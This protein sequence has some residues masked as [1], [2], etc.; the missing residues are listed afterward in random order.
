MKKLIH[1]TAALFALWF[2]PESSRAAPVLKIHQDPQWRAMISQVLIEKFE[3]KMAFHGPIRLANPELRVDLTVHDLIDQVQSIIDRDFSHTDYPEILHSELTNSDGTE[4][5]IRHFERWYDRLNQLAESDSKLRQ[6]L[7]HELTIQQ[8]SLQGIA[9]KNN[10]PFY[11]LGRIRQIDHFNSIAIE[12]EAPEIQ[13][14]LRPLLPLTVTFAQQYSNREIRKAK[15]SQRNHYENEISVINEQEAL[16]CDIRSKSNL[17]KLDAE[18]IFKTIENLPGK[19]DVLFSIQRRLKSPLPRLASGLPAMTQNFIL[20]HERSIIH[21]LKD[22][23]WEKQFNEG[24]DEVLLEMRRWLK[25]NRS[26]CTECVQEKLNQYNSANGVS[27]QIPWL[28]HRGLPHRAEV[29]ESFKTISL[30]YADNE[31]WQNE[32]DTILTNRRGNRVAIG[33]T[34]GGA[35]VQRAGDIIRNA[36]RI[37]NIAGATA[38]AGTLLLTQG[39]FALSFMTSSIVKD[40]ISNRRYDRS[41]RELLTQIPLDLAQ[42][43][44]AQTGFQPG[45]FFNLLSLGAGY[46]FT[47]GIVTK[48]DPLKSALVGA[49]MEGGIGLL[50]VSMRNPIVSGMGQA[51]MIK[52]AAIEVFTT[53]AKATL[54]GGIV[55]VLDKKDVVD[56]MKKGAIYGAGVAGLK[57]LILGTRYHPLAGKSPDDVSNTINTENQYNNLNGAPGGNYQISPDTILD[58][59][60]RQGGLLPKWIQASITLPGNISMHTNSATSIEVIVHEA[61]HLSQQEQLG[62]I[63]FYIDYLLES[64]TT[65]YQDLSF[66]ISAF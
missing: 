15:E 56:G 40:V 6:A 1:I 11:R 29:M 31:P 19:Y 57:I 10:I 46:G 20:C 26:G 12:P 2:L 3:S 53:S 41:P 66:E 62:M 36:T 37:E 52:N 65:D 44:L 64:M 22:I 48:Q 13:Q 38:G 59:P 39:N 61:H 47:Q 63:R 49:A 5:R 21:A 60:Y 35:I 54:R 42:G 33:R 50:P 28:N 24:E 8:Y 27:L 45:K 7:D 4:D 32:I 25:K 9:L 23:T 17:E 34:R 14:S 18:R 51:S 16:K 55:A 30:I 58:T 43:V